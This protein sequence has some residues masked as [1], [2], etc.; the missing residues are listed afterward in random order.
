LCL[1]R[2][3]LCVHAREMS[4]IMGRARDTEHH[5]AGFWGRVFQHA[6]LQ[7]PKCEGPL[8]R[9]CTNRIRGRRLIRLA[10]IMSLVLLMAHLGLTASPL[11]GMAISTGGQGLDSSFTRATDQG[12]SPS[13]VPQ[14]E[15]D[16]I[17]GCVTIAASPSGNS[18]DSVP[19][20]TLVQ[21]TWGLPND[22]GYALTVASYQ[23]PGWPKDPLATFQALLI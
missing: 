14:R 19:S 18:L 12:P 20:S 10:S 16:N 23:A 5:A 11:H 4:P 21:S 22:F 3:R 1:T 15:A 13:S 6:D 8:P 17:E 7:F 9:L 2:C